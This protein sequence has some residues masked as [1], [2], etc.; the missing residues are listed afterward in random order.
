MK[1]QSVALAVVLGISS[2]AGQSTSRVSVNSSGVPGEWHSDY[3]AISADGRYVAFR[4]EATDLVPGGTS[5]GQIFVHDRQ[6]GQT[7]LASSNAAG[8]WAGSI[9]SV[10]PAISGDGRYVAFRTN[11]TN[12]DPG[13]SGFVVYRKDRQTG[14][15]SG[16]AHGA[17][18]S[19]SGDGRYVAF[20]SDDATLVPNDTNGAYDVFRRDMQTGTTTRVSVTSSGGQAVLGAYVSGPSAISSDGRYVTFTSESNLVPNDV[21]GLA[22]V[23]VRDVETGQ[24]VLVSVDSSGVQGNGISG[25]SASI[26]GDGRH[27][28]F[29]SH[30]SNLVP[31]DTNG[32]LD[33]F[34]RDIQAGVTRRVSVSSAGAEAT[35]CNQPDSS[36]SGDG[37]LVA[38]FSAAS[39]LVPNDTNAANDIFLHDVQTGQ[40]TRASVNSY[41]VQANGTSYAPSI[42]ADGRCVTFWSYAS[43]LVPGDA[44]LTDTFVHER[45]YL[46]YT[47][48][49]YPGAGGVMSCPCSNPPSGFRRGCDNSSGTGGASLTGTGIA[50]LW[51][52]SLVFT[53]AGEKPTALSILLQGTTSIPA[54]V[55]FGQ[56]LRC[57]G[58][59]LKRLYNKNAVGGSIVAPD[60]GA[61][62]PTVSERSATLGDTIPPGGTRYYVVYYRDNV[63]LG[64]CPASSTFNSTQ[65]GRVTWWP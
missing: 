49:C 42:S 8:Q 37:R 57:V 51:T 54:G 56:G 44:G 48:F 7:T 17:N 4:S 63:V 39:N 3:S 19:L 5:H 58:G 27:V 10:G 64:G 29:G 23:F 24:T 15:I 13:W 40:T 12:L 31:N 38:F 14:Q 52:D 11:A 20:T 32:D 45:T 34:A 21:N 2:A 25:Y 46:A 53:T 41:G 62:D 50:Y 43:N 18:P 65:T 28:A 26:S 55:A 33:L 6:T 35:C 1:W 9:N 59:A 36:I 22:D 60:F 16:V 30:A 47:S 61:G